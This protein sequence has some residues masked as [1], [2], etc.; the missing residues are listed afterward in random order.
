MKYRVKSQLPHVEKGGI[1]DDCGPSSVAA[2]TA[3][4]AKYNPDF[5]AADGIRA[6]FEATGQV[7]KQGVSD[8]GSSL[9]QLIKT[10][11]RLGAKA[12]YAKSWE[13]V[14]AAA[15]AGAGIGVHV[16]QPRNYPAGQEV[17]AWHEKWK[18]WWWV[19]Q[20]QPTRTYGHMTSAGY[21][22]EEGVWYWAC[23]TR[24][25]VGAEAYGVKITE[26]ALKQIASS[27]GDAPHKRCI[28]ITWPAKATAPVAPTAPTPPVAPKP[29][30][31]PAPVIAGGRVAV[32]EQPKAATPK[33]EVQPLAAST[34]PAP[35]P[36]ATQLA[37]LGKVNYAQVGERALNA[38]TSAAA[39]AAKVKG[40]PAK[41][42]TFI[43][44]IKDNT[45]LDEAALE[46]ARV[47]LS[48]CIAMMLATGAPLLDMGA[49]DFKVVLSGGLA[50]ALN[51]VVRFLNPNDVAFGVKPKN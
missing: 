30:D 24:S 36:V 48:T 22:A 21:D 2:A 46:A 1:L 14:V 32:V 39:A 29:L 49:G 17:S 10:A 40:V 19:K 9:P 11:Q 7:D 23:P 13:D 26:A 3:W 31:N 42:L 8:N 34:K 4:A 38:A 18:K 50:A 15:K 41:M 27:K 25:G 12:R 45:G 43:K 44:Y 33:R 51:V 5:T 20:K 47:F 35:S 6:K 28:I 16:Q 37:A